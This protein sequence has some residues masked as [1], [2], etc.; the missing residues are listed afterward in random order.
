MKRNKK[1]VLYIF[2]LAGILVWITGCKKFLDRKPLTATLTDYGSV[3]D[4]Q[5]LGMY[6]I[7][8]SWAGFNT[9]PWLDF[10]S[11]RDDDAQKGSSTT[12]GAE[13]NTEFETFQYTK[14]DWATNTYWNDHFYMINKANQLLFYAD[15]LHVTDAASLR[16]VGEAH[17]FRAYSYFELIKA[18]GDVPK[19]DYFYTNSAEGIRPKSPVAA[20]YALIDRDLDSA[21]A[22]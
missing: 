8:D 20:I 21:S 12:D 15:S 16:N 22:L 1:V 6:S 13:V 19:I 14:D 10:N 2:L 7:F 4:G 17:F 9:L 3:L 11:I 18:Y 5:A